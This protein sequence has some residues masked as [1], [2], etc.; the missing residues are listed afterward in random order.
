MEEEVTSEGKGAG[1][2]PKGNCVC[3]KCGYKVTH[4]PGKPCRELQCPTY[5]ASMIREGSPCQQV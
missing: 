5:G 1:M 3:P 2:G 4:Q